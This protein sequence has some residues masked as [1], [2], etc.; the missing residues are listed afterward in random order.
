MAGDQYRIHNWSNTEEKK[1]IMECPTLTDAS[2]TQ[3]LHL[4]SA[5]CVEEGAKDCKG[6]NTMASATRDYVL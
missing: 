4:G 2:A 6:Q 5:E 3:L 1:V